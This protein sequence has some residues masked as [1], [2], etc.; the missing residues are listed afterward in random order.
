MR[1]EINGKEVAVIFDGTTHVCETM[2]ISVRFVSEKW[3]IEQRVVR[4]K[5][6]MN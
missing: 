3:Q 6:I 5:S 1:E 2:V 4:L